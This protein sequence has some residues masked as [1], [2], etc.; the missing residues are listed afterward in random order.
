MS[1]SL[2]KLKTASGLAALGI[3]VLAALILGGTANGGE[4]GDRPTD[5]SAD[6]VDNKVKR[7]KR[8]I[9]GCTNRRRINHGIAPLE[10]AEALERAAGLHADGMRRQGFFDHIDKQGRDPGDRVGLFAPQSRYTPIGENIGAGYDGG[11]GVCRAWMNSPGHRANMLDPDYTVI[12]AGYA[13]GG[14]LGSYFVQVFGRGPS[15]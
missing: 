13:Y 2:R 5:A 7:I 9:R 4:G 15:K 11:K 6:R 3:V 8:Q 14:R 1:N 10:P 12:G